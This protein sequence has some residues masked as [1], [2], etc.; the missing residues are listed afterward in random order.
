MH[1][2]S[3]RL[4]WKRAFF[5]IFLA[6]YRFL[7]D[8]GSQGGPNWAP[9]SIPRRQNRILVPPGGP[10]VRQGAILGR[11]WV[12]F[13]GVLRPLGSILA[14]FWGYGGSKKCKLQRISE[15]SS[16]QQQTS[17]KSCKYKAQSLKVKA[18]SSK[19][20][21]QTSELKL[22]AQSS[23]LKARSSNLKGQSSNLRAQSSKLKAQSSK[24]KAQSSKLEA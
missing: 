6:R 24:L 14:P 10:R 23:K 11:F 2:A 20:K 17:Q 15:N 5:M 19:V 1:R 8:F 3:Q 13:G 18:W 7:V 21:A 9:K 16:K 4:R 22:K 12:D